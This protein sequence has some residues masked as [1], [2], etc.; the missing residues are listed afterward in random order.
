MNKSYLVG[1]VA[2]A[3]SLGAGCTVHTYQQQPTQTAPTYASAPAP[4]AATPTI[5]KEDVQGHWSGDWG[6]MVLRVVGDEVWGAYNHDEGTVRGRVVNGRFVGW[7]CE[8]PSRGPDADAG[9]VE[10][11]FVRGPS[12]E[13]NF[14]G[15]WRY[16]TTAEWQ[17]NWDLQ[18]VSEAPSAELEARF[19][20]AAAFCPHP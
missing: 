9:E 4:V 14:D 15:K 12:G 5:Q 16:G 3:A 1:A 17:E 13:L 18:R 2:T 8:V 20:N 10:F 11:G 6:H 7:W 19:A